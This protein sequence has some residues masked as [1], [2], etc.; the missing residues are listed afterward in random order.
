MG[1]D[2]RSGM[3]VLARHEGEWRGEYVLLAPDSTVLD[4]HE[5]HLTCSFPDAGESDY[6]QRN[7]YTWSDGRVETFDFPAVYRDGRIW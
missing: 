5:S 1:H 2:I 4:R 6:F 3:P 7:I